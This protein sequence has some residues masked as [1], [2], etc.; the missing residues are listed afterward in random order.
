MVSPRMMLARLTRSAEKAEPV[1]AKS[2][3][4]MSCHVCGDQRA[5][6]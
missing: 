1:S 4:G 3:T 2:V 6:A 5:R